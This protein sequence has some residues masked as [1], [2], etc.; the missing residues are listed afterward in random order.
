MANNI[1]VIVTGTSRG[2][3]KGIV[4]LLARQ[5]LERPLTIYATSRAGVNTGIEATSPNEVKY[6][7]LDITDSL[8]IQSF[9]AKALEEHD[10]IHILIN[11]AAV[12][13]GHGEN[14]DNAA[15]TIWNNYGGTRDMCQASLSQPNIPTV[16][17]IVNLTSGL[18]ALS[19][20]GANLQSRFREASTFADIDALANKYLSDMKEG[21][22]AQERAGWRS[23]PRSYHVSKALINTLTIIL[24]K[25]HPDV[26]VNCC[27]PGWTNTDMG[28]QGSGTPP[29]TIEE[30]A[31]TAVRLAIGD[32]GPK[33]DA[34]G[35]L[36]RDGEKISG[37][38]YENENIVAKD[39]G[40][41]K[42]WLET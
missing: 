25:H 35:G 41:G 29:K 37:W 22:E 9:F 6:A 15:Q 8:S 31:M 24:E 32:L 5:K 19:T 10:G 42:N 30:G 33:G 38:F 4:T 12:S 11:N 27:C 28:K 3:G 26:L 23:G 7:A 2:V 18:N 21:A 13:P 34:D 36:G 40:K 39:W 14:P 17:R 20:Y 16:A 1:I